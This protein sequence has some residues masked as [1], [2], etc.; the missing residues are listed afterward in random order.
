MF[1][2]W[3]STLTCPHCGTLKTTHILTWKGSFGIT[4]QTEVIM[5]LTSEILFSLGLN[6]SKSVVWQRQDPTVN[7]YEY[8]K[9]CAICFNFD[10]LSYELKNGRSVC[11]WSGSP[12]AGWGA[13]GS[14]PVGWRPPGSTSAAPPA[15]PRSERRPAASSSGSDPLQTLS[16]RQCAL[17]S[18][19]SPSGNSVET[20][21]SVRKML[22]TKR[23]CVHGERAVTETFLKISH[24][25]GSGSF[26]PC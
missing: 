7:L 26:Q 5:K 12:E 11:V 22:T 13:G 9:V 4:A 25:K 17:C 14:G 1:L 6:V 23:T 2:P 16:V 3:I 24:C 8:N 20:K 21:D 15:R 18:G 10:K 19:W